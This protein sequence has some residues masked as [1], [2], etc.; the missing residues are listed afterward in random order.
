M[1]CQGIHWGLVVW[2]DVILLWGGILDWG[3]EFWKLVARCR[4][5]ND[6]ATVS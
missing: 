1:D 5:E 3:E 4:G 6:T 2:G